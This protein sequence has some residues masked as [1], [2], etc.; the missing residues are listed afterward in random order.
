[1]VMARLS[2]R[3]RRTARSLQRWSLK[4]PPLAIANRYYCNEPTQFKTV[5]YRLILVYGSNFEWPVR[6]ADL[7]AAIDRARSSAHMAIAAAPPA[8]FEMASTLRAVG[9]SFLSADVLT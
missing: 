5:R 2:S 3:R 7:M 1:M 9:Y 6:N 8:E 4:V